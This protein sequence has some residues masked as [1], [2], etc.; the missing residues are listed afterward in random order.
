MKQESDKTK[1]G[2]KEERNDEKSIDKP[3][4]HNLDCEPRDLQTKFINYTVVVG[5]TI[6]LVILIII[7][8]LV[9]VEILCLPPNFILQ[10]E[11]GGDASESGC[12]Q[13]S[14]EKVLANASE[15]SPENMMVGKHNQELPWNRF[16]LLNLFTACVVLPLGLSAILL[17][18]PNLWLD[19]SQKL[20]GKMLAT[21]SQDLHVDELKAILALLFPLMFALLLAPAGYSTAG[22]TNTCHQKVALNLTSNI[23]V[24]ICGSIVMMSVDAKAML[25]QLVK[26]GVKSHV[27]DSVEA[28]DESTKYK[29]LSSLI[30]LILSLVLCILHGSD[31]SGIILIGNKEDQCHYQLRIL[32]NILLAADLI[33]FTLFLPIFL[34]CVILLYPSCKTYCKI[35]PAPFH[36]ENDCS[37]TAAENVPMVEQN[38]V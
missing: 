23:V 7:V 16:W 13:H 19:Y 9:N 12:Y 35:P 33:I 18:I 36:C 3:R 37:E 2:R 32:S 26:L 14:F 27:K 28:I 25:K 10:M 22:W 30:M 38:I 17:S 34:R 24:I 11:Y 8:A 29:A 31:H 4:K 6:L 21:C 20:K 1:W 15:S 5:N